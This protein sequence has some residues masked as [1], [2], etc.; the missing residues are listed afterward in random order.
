MG[1]P[2]LPVPCQL[3]SRC[4]M[5]TRRS[6]LSPMFTKRSLPSPTMEN[7][8]DMLDNLLDMLD[9][10]GLEVVLTILVREF[11]AGSKKWE[12]KAVQSLEIDWPVEEES[13]ILDWLICSMY[14]ISKASCIIAP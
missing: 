5:C 13:Y 9:Q 6:Q 3:L 2:W 4:P 12:R 11:L 1:S 10:P 7:L 14:C 8:V